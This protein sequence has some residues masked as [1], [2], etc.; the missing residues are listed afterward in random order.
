MS[1]KHVID[2][3]P[4][5]HNTT[6]ASPRRNRARFRARM[7]HVLSAGRGRARLSVCSDGGP[8]MAA[9]TVRTIVLRLRVPGSKIL[10]TRF[11]NGGFRRALNRLLR[12][13]HSRFVVN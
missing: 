10:A 11:G 3:A 1:G 7:G 4:Y 2:M 13:S 9:P 5:F 12:N 6:F 8:G